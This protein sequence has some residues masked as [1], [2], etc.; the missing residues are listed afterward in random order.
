[1]ASSR[2]R[3]A[4]PT[5]GGT[6]CWPSASRCRPGAIARPRP[7]G[8]FLECEAAFPL[9]A[10][11]WLAAGTVYEWSAFPDG[12]GGQ[13]VA[14]ATSDLVEEA[15]RHYRQALVI[16]PSL[17]EA[18]LRLGRTLQRSGEPDEA[19]RGAR[20]RRRAGRRRPHG[21]SR[22]PLPGRAPRAARRDGGG[23][24]RVP[25]GPRAGPHAPAGGP[26]RGR[27]PVAR[28]RSHGHG[29]GPRDGAAQR[30]PRR[31]ADLARLPPGPRHCVPPRRSTR[32]AGRRAR[33]G[34]PS[35]P[36]CSS[37]R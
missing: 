37:S 20:A 21:G 13:R 30:V 14:R 27:D 6:G 11:A 3:D 5:S 36:C 12:L 33:E 23:G 31:P 15:K 32:C 8:F 24:S 4:T 7:S 10:E 26:R 17:A 18:R 19:A 25:Q 22:A 9:A 28:R 35:S 2:E 16:D 34:A 29:R 1:M